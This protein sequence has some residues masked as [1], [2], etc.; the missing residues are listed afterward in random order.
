[1]NRSAISV[2]LLHR[3]V[4]TAY[5]LRLCMVLWVIVGSS[6]VGGFSVSE[7]P[8]ASIFL[9]KI[10]NTSPPATRA[11]LTHHLFAFHHSMVHGVAHCFKSFTRSSSSCQ[12]TSF[13]FALVPPHTYLLTP[14]SRVL[15]EKLTS[16]LCSYSRN[17]P[18]LWNPK[19][20]HRTH[21]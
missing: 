20:P 1:M 4:Y 19:V 16:K 2:S 21:K 18:H 15:L 7:E 6:F 8:A 3:N 13:I 11:R 10:T 9:V 12:G 14:W 5:D 17:S